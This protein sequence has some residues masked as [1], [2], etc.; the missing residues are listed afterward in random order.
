MTPPDGRR[1]EVAS[2]MPGGHLGAKLQLFQISLSF[3]L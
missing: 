1:D 3:R 2:S